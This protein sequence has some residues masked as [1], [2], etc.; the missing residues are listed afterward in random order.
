MYFQFLR[1][2]QQPPPPAPPPPPPAPIQRPRRRHNMWV[3][4]W[5]LQREERGAYHNIMAHMYAIDIP[6]FTNYMR[7]TPEFFEMIKSRLEPHL[8]RQA[9]NYRAPISVGEKLALTIRYLA[10]GSPTHHCPVSSGLEDPPFP[11]FY[12]RSAG[13]SRMSSP[14]YLKCPTTPDEWKELEREFRIRWNV[15]HSL[16]ALDGKHVALKKPKNTGALYHN[17]KG[18]FSIVM[19]ALVDGQYKFRWVDA[20][21]EGSCSDGQIFNASQLKRRIE[22]GRIGFPDPAP[23]IQSGPDV[24]YF[25]LADDAFALKTWLMNPYGRRMLTREER[26]A[27]YRISRGRRVVENAFGILVSRFRVMRTTI[28]LPPATVR[29]VV[30][31]CVV[32]HNILRSQYQGQPGGQQPGE[33]DD[34][35]VPG[36]CGLIGGAAGGGQDRNPAREAKRQRDYLKG[37]FNNEGAVAWQDGR[38]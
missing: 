27:N 14:E 7:M 1:R 11:S 25:I 28:E 17:Y 36:D 9:T 22:D 18:F 35:D 37:Y 6:G 12:Q 23:I 33:D 34:D 19:L 32:L 4:P 2:P 20:G 26:I 5:L 10:T 16:G 15:P 30:F 8:A 31:T 13:P 29:E 21:T 3:R 38:L 24:P